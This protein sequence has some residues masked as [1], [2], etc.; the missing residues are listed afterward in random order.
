MVGGAVGAALV[1]WL[2]ACSADGIWTDLS[3]MLMVVMVV[4]LERIG[5][6]ESAEDGTE[7]LCG[8]GLC[9]RVERA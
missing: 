2:E 4:F 3:A 9:S 5:D 1:D 8:E 7:K 6:F